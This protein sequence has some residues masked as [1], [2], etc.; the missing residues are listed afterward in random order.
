[1]SVFTGNNQDKKSMRKSKSE[2]EKLSRSEDMALGTVQE[3]IELAGSRENLEK[4][5]AMGAIKIY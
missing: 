3:L 1:M 2:V 5:L 4:L